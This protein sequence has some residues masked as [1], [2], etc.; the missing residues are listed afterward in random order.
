MKY[1]MDVSRN[2]EGGVSLNPADGFDTSLDQDWEI[3]KVTAFT[4]TW[5]QH[6][7]M[8]LVCRLEEAGLV[9]VKEHE[10]HTSKKLLPGTVVHTCN[11]S[12]M[13]L[14]KDGEGWKV[15]AVDSRKRSV[16]SELD[17]AL[18]PV[19]VS[20]EVYSAADIYVLTTTAIWMLPKLIVLLPLMLV[21]GFVPILMTRVYITLLP[22]PLD[23][24]PRS[25]G[26][27]FWFCVTLLCALPTIC[28]ILV[29]LLLDSIMYYIF[30]FV[31]CLVTCQWG[32]LW[33]NLD[34][35]RPFRHGPSLFWKMPDIWLCIM[36]QHMRQG[37]FETIYIVSMMW[38]LMPWLKFYINCNPW[39]YELDHRLVQQIS[40]SLSDIGNV[41]EV[42]EECRHVIS[43][44]RHSRE[45][46]HRIDLWS[47]VP[48]Y[49]YPP[50]DRRWAIGIQAGGAAYPGKFTLL[51]HTTHADSK[52]GSSRVNTRGN[53]GYG[54]TPEEEEVCTHLGSQEQFVLSNSI[55]RPVYRV[56]RWYNNPFHFLTGWVEAS[57]STGYPSQPQ[58]MHG[59]EHPMWLVSAKSKLTASRESF[60]GSGLI[61]WFFDYWL[62]VFVHGV[63]FALKYRTLRA[64]QD[65]PLGEAFDEA[66]AYADAMYQQVKSQDGASP[67]K[68]KKG[69]DKY[70]HS[71]L[72]DYRAQGVKENKEKYQHWDER[73][74]EVR[75]ST[76]GIFCQREC[77]LGRDLLDPVD[78]LVDV[79]DEH[80]KEEKKNE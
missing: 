74:G 29:N 71:T 6:L 80:A 67:A 2:R 27:Y 79:N 11:G 52:M 75:E 45:R 33:S 35:I 12:E 76:C 3:P 55:A 39:I 7:K 14:C 37:I 50:A 68:T 18:F 23:R 22:E 24:V 10:S 19:T 8:D 59:G 54:R 53:K 36:G 61:D 1:A 47:F 44:A 30:S 60:T 34:K 48:H 64:E 73:L 16:Q 20:K 63:R 5:E 57:I 69:L 41:D 58:K 15:A 38:V 13:R 66:M 40:T 51:V 21:L 70:H 9:V 65:K 56:M 72:A 4:Y 42:A 32:I 31:Y 26:F 78:D 46:A 17:E 25:H 28:G 49:P 62:P 43:R 77:C